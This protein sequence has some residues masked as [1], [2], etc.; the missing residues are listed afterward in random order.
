MVNKALPA[1]SYA[2]RKRTSFNQ[3]RRDSGNHSMS[4]GW[5][6]SRPKRN[7][8]NGSAAF[9]PAGDALPVTVI[10]RGPTHATLS[11]G[12]E[13]WL[14][15]SYSEARKGP[16]VAFVPLTRT[17]D[18]RLASSLKIVL[19]GILSVVS[20]R[21]L[22]RDEQFDFRPVH[23]TSLQLACSVEWV[24]RNLGEKRL[25]GAVLLDVAKAFFAVWVNGLL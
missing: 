5:Q 25:T 23:S 7:T 22:M 15:A 10:K 16:S 9:F 2:P 3:H 6:A 13:A 11:T 14:N 4:Q 20:G 21:W 19:T 1:Y 24:T 8:E 18:R 12:L 17:S